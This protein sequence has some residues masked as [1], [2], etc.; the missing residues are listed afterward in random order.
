MTIAIG[1]IL[2]ILIWATTPLSIQWSS[3]SLSFVAAASARMVLAL[4]LALIINALF[5]R[6][7][8]FAQPGAWKVYLA[9]AIGI[10]PNMPLV[11]W[12]AQFIPSGVIAVVFAL[13]PFVTGLMTLLIL[14]QNPFTRR[15]VLAL[16]VAVAGLAV[17][18]S[19][20][21]R[22]DVQAAIGML[23][24]LGSSVLFSFSSVSLKRLNTTVDPFNQAA[25]AL[26]F[27]VPGLLLCWWLLDGAA[28]EAVSVKSAGAVVYL[29]VMGSLVGFTLFFYVL[30]HT[31]ASA[32]SLTT[33][34]TP[35]LALLLG[36]W[37]AGERLTLSVLIGS[38]LV[39]VA[40]TVY[41]EFSPRQW[42]QRRGKRRQ[43]STE[44]ALK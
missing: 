18:F 41:L 25:G 13:S 27:A 19:E 20:Q 10:F 22:I 26:L 12:S 6:P 24:I 35:V 40:L 28:P 11:Y 42:L 8:L 4:V 29:A 7:A 14:R 16:V 2:V 9:A 38:V 31:S 32:V 39:L 3:D 34:I 33:L 36:A 43:S 15:R 23:G 30:K 5:N 37:V 21:W 1:F 44:L 17:I